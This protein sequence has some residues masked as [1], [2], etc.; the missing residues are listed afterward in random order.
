MQKFVPSPHHH[1]F[2]LFSCFYVLFFRKNTALKQL[3]AIFSSPEKSGPRSQKA[4]YSYELLKILYSSLIYCFSK[5]VLYFTS[6]SFVSSFNRRSPSFISFKMSTQ[7]P[8]F[9]FYSS[10]PFVN[11]FIIKSPLSFLFINAS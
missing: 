5:Y 11:N 8:F 4:E 3:S 2:T 1:H 10:Q 9:S 7:K 6:C